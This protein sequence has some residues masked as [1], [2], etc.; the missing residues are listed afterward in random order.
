MA[1][2]PDDQ[3]LPPKEAGLFKQ[4]IRMYENKQYKNALKTCNQILKKFPN[5]GGLPSYDIAVLFS[6]HVVNVL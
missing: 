3:T 5:H 4:V 6:W 2:A 1:S